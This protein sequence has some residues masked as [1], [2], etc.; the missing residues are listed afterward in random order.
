MSSRAGSFCVFYTGN[1]KHK[2][3]EVLVE[4]MFK[5]SKWVTDWS[6]LTMRCFA[7]Y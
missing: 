5:Y 6:N 3:V 1:V 4:T 2:A 7:G